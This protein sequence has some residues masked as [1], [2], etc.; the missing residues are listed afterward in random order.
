MKNFYFLFPTIFDMGKEKGQPTKSRLAYL[1]KQQDNPIL[2]NHYLFIKIIVSLSIHERF[3][4]VAYN[5]A[6]L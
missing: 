2:L 5:G 4:S 6:W 1:D 3:P